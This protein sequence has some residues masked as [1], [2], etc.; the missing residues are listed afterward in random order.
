MPLISQPLVLYKQAARYDD[1]DDVMSL[2]SSGVSLDSKDS[3]GRT[4]LSFWN[5]LFDDL[6]ATLSENIIPPYLS[7][8]LFDHLIVTQAENINNVEVCDHFKYT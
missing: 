4:G 6:V 1:L 2:A 5:D 8:A 3:E 7:N